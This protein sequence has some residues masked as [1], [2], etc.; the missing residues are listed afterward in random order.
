LQALVAATGEPVTL[1]VD[2]GP[3]PALAEGHHGGVDVR[4][5]RRRGPGGADDRIVDE[6]VTLAGAS[7]VEV[8]TSDREL[9]GRARALGA[10]VT[11]AG[12]LLARLDQLAPI[13][14]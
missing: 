6:V 7:P 2:G 4:Y 9:A 8:V 5:A 3:G 12:A 1:V 10:T 13:G 11:G 14:L